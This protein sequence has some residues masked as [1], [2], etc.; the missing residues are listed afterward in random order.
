MTI[1]LY[2]YLHVSVSLGVCVCIHATCIF[3]YVSIGHT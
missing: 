3:M 2:I 1:D